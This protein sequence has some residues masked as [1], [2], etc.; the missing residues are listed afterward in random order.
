MTSSSDSA[1]RLAITRLERAASAPLAMKQ[2]HIE[3]ALIGLRAALAPTHGKAG[4][5]RLSS[6]FCARPGCGNTRPVH[7]RPNCPKF[8]E[9]DS[10]EARALRALFLVES[11]PVVETPPPSVDSPEYIA[12]EF[13]VEETTIVER[14][15]TDAE[16]LEGRT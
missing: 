7:P 10:E 9:K 11:T 2:L 3:A 12:L 13:D 1:I 16:I 6:R 14:T 8:V 15:P 5:D 4:T